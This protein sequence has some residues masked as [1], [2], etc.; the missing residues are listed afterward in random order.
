VKLHQAYGEYVQFISIAIT[1]NGLTKDL[2]LPWNQ[3]IINQESDFIKSL[4][5]LNYPSYVLLDATGNIVA[6]PALG[7]IPK[8]DYET[9]EPTF[10]QIKRI[11]TG[12]RRRK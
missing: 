12:E 4:K 8:N 6:N 7:P 5:I 10:F 3:V 9:I 1:S 2:E 11:I